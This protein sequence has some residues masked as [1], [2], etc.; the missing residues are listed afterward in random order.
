MMLKLMPSR[1][2]T[3]MEAASVAGTTSTAINVTRQLRRNS[4]ST[5]AASTRPISTASRTLPA[6]WVTSSLW[7]YQFTRRTPGGSLNCVELGPHGAGD[8][9]RVAVRLLIDV[10]QHGRLAVL[11]D[12]DPLRH[13]A[14]LHAG[15]IAHPND[16]GGVGPHHHVA[17]RCRSC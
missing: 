11:H 4:S 16:P 8:L 12:A 2:S 9:H 13:D 14:V 3:R 15:D 10:E 7:S 1:L 5:R 6:D 17:D